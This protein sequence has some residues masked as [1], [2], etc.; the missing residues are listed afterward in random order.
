MRSVRSRTYCDPVNPVI[1]PFYVDDDI[2][3]VNTCDLSFRTRPYKAY[4]KSVEDGGA[5]ITTS[6][7]SSLPLLQINTSISEPYSGDHRHKITI[8]QGWVDH[9]HDVSIPNHKHNLVFGISSL[10]QVSPSS[11][12][13][14]VD[15]NVIPNT[16]LS[17]DRLSIIDYLTKQNGKVT[18]GLHEIS[19]KPT[20]AIARIE[21]NVILRVFIQSRIGGVY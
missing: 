21:A 12:T 16:A 9:T 10:T 18:R 3:N 5:E 14:T 20:D 4:S 17:E 19:I 8:G 7:E 6:G 11:L 15:G 1:I 2:V 13:I